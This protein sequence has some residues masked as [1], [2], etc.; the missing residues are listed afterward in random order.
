MVKTAKTRY[1]AAQFHRL[2]KGSTNDHGHMLKE[3]TKDAQSS[4][5]KPQRI[6]SS[7]S[8]SRANIN[9]QGIGSQLERKVVKNTVIPNLIV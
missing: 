3:G 4:T 9:V 1:Q 8:K 6:R 5:D 2:Y 7:D